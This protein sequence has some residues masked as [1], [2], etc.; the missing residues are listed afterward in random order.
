MRTI[1]DYI[2][3]AGAVYRKRFSIRRQFSCRAVRWFFDYLLDDRSG[4]SATFELE[5][6]TSLYNP[7]WR[8][9]LAYQPNLGGPFF[10]RK[11][12]LNEFNG[13]Q[14]LATSNPVYKTNAYTYDGVLWPVYQVAEDAWDVANARNYYDPN[15][16][17]SPRWTSDNG[18]PRGDLRA[19]GL[20]LM[21]RAIPTTPAYSLATSLGELFSERKL[22]SIPGKS[23]L[24]S[25]P[26]GDWLNLQFGVLPVI[27]DVQN[28]M[29]AHKQSEKIVSQYMR[30][31]NKVVR[32]RREFP[33][34][35][36]T[37]VEIRTG[38]QASLLDGIQ[39]S[40]TLAVAL[41][42]NGTL[43]IRTRTS[44]RIW[45]SGAFTHYLPPQA[46]EWYRTMVKMNAL[47]G[48]IPTPETLWQLTPFS[49]LSD[50][51]T[52]T[53][54]VIRGIFMAGTDGSVLVR[55]YVMC[56]SVIDTEYTW[57]GDL[58]INGSW[59]RSVLTWSLIE[60]IK[61]RERTDS[62]GVD[63]SGVDLS[64]KQLSILA[65]LGLTKR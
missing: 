55:G 9:R 53:Q 31:A 54:D 2:D 65:A 45:F 61:Q 1:Q 21:L 52:N 43:H 36:E 16:S 11:V 41:S 7:F 48:V 3:D 29:E 4:R 23:T 22:F 33:E 10:N 5:E 19:A 47:Y 63:W 26:Q 12:T 30:D 32:R 27:S 14:H 40:S 6:T 24:E 28:A 46:G 56:H 44:R 49:W 20:K 60:E 64:A 13:T 42:Q 25:Q 35:V 8:K 39:R 59:K 58:M 62:Y 15:I 18:M 17:K 50:W 37:S 38:A 34:T 57:T 51:F